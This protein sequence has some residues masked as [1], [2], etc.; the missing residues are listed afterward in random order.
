VSISIKEIFLAN[1]NWESYQDKYRFMTRPV[2]REEVEKMLKCRDYT[3]GHTTYECPQCGHTTTIPFT[4]KSRLCTV[5][6]KKHTDAW[7]DKVSKELLE[8]THRH[9]VFTMP[10]KLWPYMEQHRQLLK[11]VMDTVKTTLEAVVNHRWTALQVVPGIITVLHTYGKDLKFNPHIHAIVTEGGLREKKKDPYNR[12][13][14]VDVNFF[15]YEK[16][17]KVWQYQLLTIIREKL[18]YHKELHRLLDQLYREK[19]NGFYV[20]AK[21]R[22]QGQQKE[23]VCRYVAR[24]VR[25]PAIAETRIDNYDPDTMMVEFW[26]RHDDDT[27][28]VSMHVYEFIGKLVSHIPP[29]QFKTIR[30]YGLY[31]RNKKRRIQDILIRLKRF[32]RKLKQLGLHHYRYIRTC[33]WQP[34]L[35][36]V[37]PECGTRMRFVSLYLPG[38]G[39]ITPE[40]GT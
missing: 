10:D 38:Q 11:D 25:H 33:P 22:I 3:Q 6:G 34:R 29:R 35:E 20:Y 28:T 12:D 5:C 8:V 2:E 32:T 19:E 21:R 30:Y 14:W 4:C 23:S 17:R 36:P 18:P 37:C 40:D 39:Y 24:Y 16:L 31:A 27:E 1:Q 26:Y 7:A 13:R 9:M 15:P